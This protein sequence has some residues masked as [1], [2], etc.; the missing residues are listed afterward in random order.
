MIIISMSKT[1]LSPLNKC[2]FAV[3]GKTFKEQYWRACYD[4]FGQDNAGAC[5]NCVSLCHEGHELG[6]LRFSTFFCDCGEQHM[7]KV[8]EFA[9]PPPAYPNLQQPESTSIY[10]T[11]IGQPVNTLAE[12]LFNDSDSGMLLSPLSIVYALSLVHLGSGDNTEAEL[13]QLFGGKYSIDTLKQM[14]KLFNNDVIKMGNCFA[15]NSSMTVNPEYIKLLEQVA[16]I[17]NAPFNDELKKKLNDY[18]EQNTNGLIKD[19]I[20]VLDPYSLAVLINTVYFKAKWLHPFEKDMT[21]KMEFANATTKLQVDMMWQKE[22]HMYYEDSAIQLVELPYIGKE[23]YM[24][25]LLPRAVGVIPE[26]NTDQLKIAIQSLKSE[27]VV[28][29]LP[30]FTQRKNLS[31][32]TKLKQVGVNSLFTA[33]ANLD[34]IASGAFV[35]DVI[36]EAVVIVDEEGTEAAATTVVYMSKSLS[37]EKI[38]LFNANHSFIYYIRHEPSNTILFVGDYHG[39]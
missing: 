4:C 3:T 23:Y 35:T 21:R 9:K 38:T 14:H 2:T 30:K 24:G 12:K 25:V 36:H 8:G 32:V 20:K 7:C 13:T 6:P 27:K 1:Q 26:L 10:P 19:V 11:V 29:F 5:L 16:L 17:I 18:I 37:M 33:G 31:L 15:V 28:L 34:K 39:N 22:N